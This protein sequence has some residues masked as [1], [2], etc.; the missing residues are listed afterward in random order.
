MKDTQKTS[1]DSHSIIKHDIII[2][3]RDYEDAYA[4]S[5]SLLETINQVLMLTDLA[6]IPPE[7]IYTSIR[8]LIR[9]LQSIESLSDIYESLQ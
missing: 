1:M 7:D 5:T 3:I 2:S 4:F 6:E 8:S 9:I